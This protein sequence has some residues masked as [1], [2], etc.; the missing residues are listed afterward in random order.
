MVD[1][2]NSDFII[3]KKFYDV[4][5][6]AASEAFKNEAYVFFKFIETTSARRANILKNSTINTNYENFPQQTLDEF[7]R[8]KYITKAD[9][10]DC[11]VLTAK[12]LF[13]IEEEL[14]FVN[15]EKFLTD[16]QAKYFDLLKSK[17]KL[18]D[19]EKIVLFSLICSRSFSRDVCMKLES[20]GRENKSWITIFRKC[21]T[22]L[23]RLNVISSIPDRITQEVEEYDVPLKYFMS[24]INHL[25]EKIGNVYN[26][27]KS[28]RY[29]LELGN[30]GEVLEE[31]LRTLFEKIFDKVLTISE[32]DLVNEFINKI[33]SDDLM[34]MSEHRGRHYSKPEI[35]LIIERALQDAMIGEL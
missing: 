9:C 20:F 25:Q 18:S 4:F 12:G 33:S 10:R 17:A 21:S 14:G 22:F 2:E 30:N 28:R 3:L 19:K 15:I 7:V 1:L 29:Y 5:V 34:K 32:I 16:V 31:S 35:D 6:S 23:K 8:E 24:H 13:H 26:F 27:T 11:Y